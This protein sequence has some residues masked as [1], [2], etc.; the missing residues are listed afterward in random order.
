MGMV[1]TKQPARLRESGA[2]NVSTSNFDVRG[3][4]QTPLAV[5]LGNT[6]CGSPFLSFPTNRTALSFPFVSVELSF[7]LS[8][9]VFVYLE[10]SPRDVTLWSHLGK[11]EGI[12]SYHLGMGGGVSDLWVKARG[13]KG[14]TVCREV[15]PN[16]KFS[17]PNSNN[18]C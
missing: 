12:F 8:Q 2:Q 14:P 9:G 11:Y 10:I 6:P 18:V 15:P 7:K 16:K 1:T 13:A 5:G 17:H 3:G 4:L